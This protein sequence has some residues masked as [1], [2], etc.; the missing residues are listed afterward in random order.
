[1]TINQAIQIIHDKSGSLSRKEIKTMTKS[2]KKILQS[3]FNVKILG[4]KQQE[5]I[6]KALTEK[7]KTKIINLAEKLMGSEGKTISKYGKEEALKPSTLV[8]K[9]LKLIKQT[10][11]IRVAS[12]DVFSNFAIEQSKKSAEDG[13][14]DTQNKLGIA[15]QYG[16]GVNK[17]INKAIKYYRQS[18]DQGNADAQYNLGLVYMC[19]IGVK[20]DMNEAI[21]YYKIS[22][23]QGN[24][25]AQNK[26][27][28]VYE[29]GMGLEQDVN[30][31]MTYYRA[32]ANQGNKD[33]INSLETLQKQLESSK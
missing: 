10:F 14:A 24:A 7:Q 4:S 9:A 16:F 30:E 8:E 27:G 32:A 20:E 18:A 17:D 26:L 19:G 22:A 5:K 28:M 31:A 21:R 6:V 23:D 1:M 29:Y 11:G 2:D 15:Y 13:N 3:E 33:A 12:K 25:D